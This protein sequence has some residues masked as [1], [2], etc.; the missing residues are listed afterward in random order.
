MEEQEQLRG[1]LNMKKKK[2]KNNKRTRRLTLLNM[3]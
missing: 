3:W 1:L 2:K